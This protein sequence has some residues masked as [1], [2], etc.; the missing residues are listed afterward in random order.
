MSSHRIDE[1]S[2]TQLF[3]SHEC[4]GNGL[5]ARFHA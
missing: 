5:P 1:Q 4:H 3:G 2:V